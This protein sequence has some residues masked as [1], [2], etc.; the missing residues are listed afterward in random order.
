MMTDQ[1]SALAQALQSAIGEKSA[2]QQQI[3]IIELLYQ[4]YPVMK[5]FK[6][7]MIGVHKELEKALP[8]FGANHVH[9]SIAAHCRKVRYLKSVA[10]GGKRFD[11]NGKPV[12][13]VTAEEKAAAAKFVQNIEDRKKPQTAATA[14]E[15]AV[16]PILT[17]EVIAEADITGAE[18]KAE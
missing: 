12:G 7:L 17:S 13:D 4:R 11:L 5:Q 10:R 1:N 14:E 18:N 3:M 16:D 6:P 15:V 2:R 8:Q 9:R